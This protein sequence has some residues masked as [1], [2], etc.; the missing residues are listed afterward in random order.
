MYRNAKPFLKWVTLEEAKQLS[1]RE[2]PRFEPPSKETPTKALSSIDHEPQLK[3]FVVPSIIVDPGTPK[4]PA[5]I[6]ATTPSIETPQ[7]FEEN[8][9]ATKPSIETP[10]RIE[11]KNAVTTPSIETPQRFDEKNAA[12]PTVIVD[13]IDSSPHVDKSKKDQIPDQLRKTVTSLGNS[14]IENR[15]IKESNKSGDLGSKVDNNVAN[16]DIQTKEREN[17][18]KSFEKRH[19]EDDISELPDDTKSELLQQK[20]AKVTEVP[21]I[22]IED[23]QISSKVPEIQIENEDNGNKNQSNLLGLA[24]KEERSRRF[25]KLP[26]ATTDNPNTVKI[27]KFAVIPTID[28]TE[29]PKNK[30]NAASNKDE[31]ANK[32]ALE[33]PNL[34]KMAKDLPDPKAPISSLVAPQEKSRR[35]SKLPPA[36]TND[37]NAVKLGHFAVI[38]TPEVNKQQPNASLA[39]SGQEKS[40]RFSKLPPASVDNPNAVKMG[41]K[42][43]MISREKDAKDTK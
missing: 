31:P 27:S 34:Q 20:P 32:S 22:T 16:V 3:A 23:S 2:S 35:F 17:A 42:F 40:R 14:V 33:D 15:L 28:D 41:S 10:Q 43:T 7:R 25:S 26:P 37:P 38:P 39:V 1:K 4:T 13:E 30:Q 5:K 9:A 12:I 24:Q 8:N 36:Q 29:T 21:D 19:N 18:D 11:E 6:L